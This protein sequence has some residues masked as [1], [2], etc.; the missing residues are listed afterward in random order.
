MKEIIEQFGPWAVLDILIIAA[1]IY[2]I[3]LLIRGTRAAQILTGILVIFA[4]FLLSS[5][6]PLTTLNWAM[7]KFYA[8]F[9]II[10]IILF[11]DDIRHALSRIGKKSFISSSEN[12]SSQRV[13]DEITR[14]AVSLAER[15]IGALIVLERNII[16]SRY[17]DI[18]ILLDARISKELLQS[19]FHTSSP[20]H[21]GAVI[22]QQGRATAAGCFLPLTKEENV[23]P[24]K[25]TRHRAAIGISQ[26]TDA[27]VVIVS[28]EKGRFS[29][30]IDGTIIPLKTAKDLRKALRKHMIDE[31]EYVAVSE[32]SGQSQGQNRGLVSKLRSKIGHKS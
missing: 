20:I 15:K 24:D 26:E 22:V 5:S 11:Q 1:I 12:V 18:G 29:L 13:Y 9:I 30:V 10:L 32:Q 19:I 23:D 27:V 3:L 16:L 8:S 17:I 2:Q 6:V 7:N 31:P 28:E 25:G 21:D 4:A 14:A